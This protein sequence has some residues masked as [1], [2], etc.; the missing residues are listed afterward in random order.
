M[1]SEPRGTRRSLRTDGRGPRRV[2]GS[3][4]VLRGAF[5]PLFLSAS[6]N[7]SQ[8]LS[9]LL[10]DEECVLCRIQNEGRGRSFP[11]PHGTWLGFQSRAHSEL[12]CPC[13]WA[14]GCGCAVSTASTSGLPAVTGDCQR[15]LSWVPGDRGGSSC[16]A[17]E[18]LL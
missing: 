3:R 8:A 13:P 10:G 16:L 1:E 17:S 5:S 15:R 11:E 18:D 2:R 9:C 14:C 6:H 7:G 12:P 4:C